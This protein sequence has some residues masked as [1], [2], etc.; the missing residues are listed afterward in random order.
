[1]RHNITSLN[2]K[3]AL[4][5]SLKK[6]MQKKSFSKI[7]I[8]EISADC[9][10]NRKTF[11]Y[12]FNDL[13][14]LLKWIFKNEAFEIISRLNTTANYQEALKFAMDYIDKNDYIIHCAYDA[15]GR[16]E[17]SRCFF[18][19]FKNLISSIIDHAEKEAGKTLDETYKNYL[20]LF[21][22]EAHI[23]TM[24]DWIKNRKKYDRQQTID[25]LVK[26]MHDS[27]M[28]ILNNV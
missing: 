7:T 27:L 6:C 3:K 9:G 24:I 14:D 5:K 23:G 26:I 2:T 10:V 28:G 25:Y 1:M 13:N 4:A 16:D 12:H 19:D 11:Y 21:F 8:S 17:L 18:D 20:C 22:T 15:I